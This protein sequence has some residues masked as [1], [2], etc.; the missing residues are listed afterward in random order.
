MG[1][2]SRVVGG[3]GRGGKIDPGNKIDL[4]LKTEYGCPSGGD[5]EY[6]ETEVSECVTKAFR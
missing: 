3:G 1:A 6:I 4:I 2:V 5:P